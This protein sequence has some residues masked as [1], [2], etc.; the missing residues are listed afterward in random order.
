MCGSYHDT[1]RKPYRSIDTFNLSPE[2][3]CLGLCVDGAFRGGGTW[4]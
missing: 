1:K 2:E 3:R 4:G